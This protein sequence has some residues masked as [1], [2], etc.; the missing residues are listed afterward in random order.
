MPAAQQPSRRPQVWLNIRR[1]AEK[2]QVPRKIHV[3]FVCAMNR[4]RSV[5]A[6]RIYRNDQRLEVRSAGVASDAER[7]VSGKDLLWADV[8]YTMERSH[9][10]RIIE[11]F[12]D[13]ELPPIKTL[14]IPDDF[15]VMSS[16]LVGI[17][18]SLLDPEFDYLYTNWGSCPLDDT[19]P[20]KSL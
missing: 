17:L 6:E 20:N 9:K 8:V 15:E 16:T 10:R 18:H 14:D 1:S 4:Q 3:L 2:N 11:Q 13:L 5:T 19:L 12:R 7:R